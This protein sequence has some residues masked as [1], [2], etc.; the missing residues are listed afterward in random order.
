MP[1]RPAHPTAPHGTYR[2]YRQGCREACCRRANAR[3]TNLRRL[4]MTDHLL[5]GTGT[6]RRIRALRRIGWRNEDIA[7][8]AGLHRPSLARLLQVKR[9]GTLVQAA[10]AAAVRRAY[11]ALSMTAGPYEQAARLALREGWPPPLAWDDDTIDDPAVDPYGVRGDEPVRHIGRGA[12]S[13]VDPEE[14]LDLL[15]LGE[16]AARIAD[17]VGVKQASLQKTL[18]RAGRRDVWLR[19]SEAERD[20]REHDRRAA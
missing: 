9:D 11:D 18:E 15:E 5:D 1:A 19:V 13:S 20:R 4:G 12:T 17:L 10:T 14:V 7:A 6:R 3:R 8:A 2:R 16:P